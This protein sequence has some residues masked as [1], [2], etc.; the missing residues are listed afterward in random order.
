MI[1][2]IIRHC[3]RPMPGAHS[4]V[5]D[6]DMLYRRKSACRHLGYYAGRETKS[7]RTTPD[8]VAYRTYAG[9]P[10]LGPDDQAKSGGMVRIPKR[11][12]KFSGSAGPW[13]KAILTI[14]LA[15]AMLTVG[16]LP[17][18][19]QY[20]PQVPG[21]AYDYQLWVLVATAPFLVIPPAALIYFVVTGRRF[22][23]TTVIA[24]IVMGAVAIAAVLFGV[25]E[26]RFGA[27]TVVGIIAFP[28]LA[29]V[30]TKAA[31]I[32]SKK[33][34]DPSVYKKFKESFGAA[35]DVKNF[36]ELLLWTIAWASAGLGVFLLIKAIEMW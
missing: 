21:S 4:A 24:F 35:L 23:A 8:P 26:E 10:L 28:L 14:A 27:A 15:S 18:V 11:V 36:A 29:A 33:E 17:W 34:C 20:I 9:T 12:P 25:A 2:G 5:T 22:V 16:Y 1:G 6:S 7:G 31:N 30:A 19:T 13:L 3:R 32:A